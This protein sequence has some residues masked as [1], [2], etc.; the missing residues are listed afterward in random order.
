MKLT[1][2]CGK[3]VHKATIL[4]LKDIKDFTKRKIITARCE[5]CHNVVLTLSETRISDGK[6]FINED[7][8]GNRAKSILVRE[9][10]NIIDT[11]Q[12]KDCSRARWVYGQNVQIRNKKGQVTQI[13][14]YSKDFISGKRTLEKVIKGV[15]DTPSIQK[16]ERENP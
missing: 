12:I 7:I 3:V 8:Y 9:K 16:G 1:C 4:Y 11:S 14:Q 13:R 5:H 10:N 6:V 15:V 2:G